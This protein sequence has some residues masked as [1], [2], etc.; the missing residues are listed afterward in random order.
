MRRPHL[1]RC[2]ALRI[3][4]TRASSDRPHHHSRPTT[5]SYRSSASR[6][7]PPMG[8]LCGK[9]S[10][11][12]PAAGRVLGSG[13]APPPAAT[14][15]IPSKASRPKVASGRGRTLGDVEGSDDPRAAAARA[16]EVNCL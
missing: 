11:D 6:P 5:A 1:R 9:E 4:T 12:G 10:S 2:S 14:S 16:A 8:N 15:K 13:S 7:T 3:F